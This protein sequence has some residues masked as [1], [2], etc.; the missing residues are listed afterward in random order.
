MKI[1]RKK[2]IK[3]LQSSCIIHQK[4]LTTFYCSK[5]R[6]NG[7]YNNLI[8][9]IRICFDIIKKMVVLFHTEQN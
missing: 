8:H 1:E 4:I 5:Q 7:Q 9:I 6:W 2:K 3:H